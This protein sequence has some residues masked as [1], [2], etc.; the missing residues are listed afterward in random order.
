MSVWDTNS[1]YCVYGRGGCGACKSGCTLSAH[2]FDEPVLQALHISSSAAA[3]GAGGADH[4]LPMVEA[5][6]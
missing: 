3:V 2:K 6:E 5:R 4:S 1:D